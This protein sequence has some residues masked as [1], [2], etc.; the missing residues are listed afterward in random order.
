MG[1]SIPRWLAVAGARDLPHHTLDR[2]R[3]RVQSSK[4]GG[5]KK[6]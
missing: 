2:L 1:G 3:D 4:S 5:D 6:K